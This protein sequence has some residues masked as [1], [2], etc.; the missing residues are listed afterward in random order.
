MTREGERIP[1]S[2]SEPHGCYQTGLVRESLNAQSPQREGGKSR[3]GTNG[4]AVDRATA[5]KKASSLCRCST[6]G[7][8]YGATVP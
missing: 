3:F 1:G 5:S 7:F 8:S 6:S 2:Q 4:K